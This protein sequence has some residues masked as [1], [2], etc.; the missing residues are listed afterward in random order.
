LPTVIVT[1]ATIDSIS[2]TAVVFTAGATAAPTMGSFGKTNATD[3]ATFLGR[4]V[5]F[6][7]ENSKT[8]SAKVTELASLATGA[9]TVAPGKMVGTVALVLVRGRMDVATRVNG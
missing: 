9:G 5:L 3:T 7:K 8:G 2:V 1:K 6:T 4:T